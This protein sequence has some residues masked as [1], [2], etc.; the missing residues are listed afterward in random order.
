MPIY[1][2]QCEKT[3]NVFEVNQTINAEPLTKC[4]LADCKCEGTGNVHRLIS[5]NVGVIFNG[6]GFY[7]TDYIRKSKPEETMPTSNCNNC[8]GSKGCP[9]AQNF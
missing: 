5:K 4:N 2:Y 6:S 8:A 9:A 3:G 1:E 7:E